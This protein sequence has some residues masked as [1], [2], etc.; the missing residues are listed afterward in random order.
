MK[1]KQLNNTY[2]THTT[3]KPVNKQM[4]TDRISEAIY[5]YIYT[6]RPSSA[7]TRTARPAKKQNVSTQLNYVLC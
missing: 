5:I 3:N 7:S 2:N 4:S 1:S 6:Y